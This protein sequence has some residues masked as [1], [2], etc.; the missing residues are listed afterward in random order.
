VCD[1]VNSPENDQRALFACNCPFDTD[2]PPRVSRK[3]NS[4]GLHV[5]VNPYL[6]SCNWISK[7]ASRLCLQDAEKLSGTLQSCCFQ[8]IIK[9][10]RNRFEM[11]AFHVERSGEME[12]R[13]QRR[14]LHE[15]SDRSN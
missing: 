8:I 4:P 14:N 12:M 10:M 6:I 5:K 11:S 15:F 13:R 1:P 2:W 7:M 9:K 3:R